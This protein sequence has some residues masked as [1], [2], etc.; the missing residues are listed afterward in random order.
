MEPVPSTQLTCTQCGGELH[1][2]EGTVFITCPYCSATV[3][4]DKS[5]VVFHWHLAPTLN[6][7]QAVAALFRW[8]SGSATVKD[9]DRKARISYKAFQYFPLWYF[10]WQG[11]RGE[12]TALQP[13]AATSLTEIKHLALP[14]G[15]LR[16]YDVTLDPL[17]LPPS[18]PLEAAL[19]WAKRDNPQAEMREGALVHIPLYT[20]KYE[21][22][23]KTFTAVVEAATGKVLASIYPA[24][25]EAPY[26]TIGIITALVFLC[27]AAVPVLTMISDNGSVVAV[28]TLVVLILAALAAP[29]LFAI[30]MWVASKV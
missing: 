25:S 19:S 18:V 10:R 15:D 3:Y 28:T 9:L 21:Y 5:R 7:Q 11:K 13:A 8:M 29:V 14:G 1:P 26:L 24:K 27:L 30:A 22:Q 4:L 20:F 16:S 12:D 23:S 17:S 2:D 6:E